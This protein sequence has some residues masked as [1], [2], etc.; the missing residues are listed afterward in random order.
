MWFWRAKTVFNL[1][2]IKLQNKFG[3]SKVYQGIYLGYIKVYP[4]TLLIRQAET[5]PWNNSS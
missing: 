2:Y 4:R 3:I 1:H 5:G